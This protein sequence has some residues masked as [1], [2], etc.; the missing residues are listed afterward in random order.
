MADLG[1]LESIARC[2][3]ADNVMNVHRI[4]AKLPIILIDRSYVDFCW[5]EVQEGRFAHH[6]NRQHLD[7]TIYRPDNPSHRKWQH[8]KSFAQHHHREHEDSVTESYL[9]Q[10]P[11]EAVRAFLTF[12]R[13]IILPG[14]THR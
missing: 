9:P 12:C 5:S 2:E 14:E 1:K 3:F 6:W 4:D 13:Q 7:G 8:I 11:Q 10:D